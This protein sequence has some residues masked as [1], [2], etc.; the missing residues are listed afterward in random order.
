MFKTKIHNPVYT[1]ERW[2]LV[3][4]SGLVSA[5]RQPFIKETTGV[6]LSFRVMLKCANKIK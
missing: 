3:I 4:R 5:I 2:V 1:R 6:L